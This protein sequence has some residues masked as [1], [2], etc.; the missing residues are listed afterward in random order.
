MEKSVNRIYFFDYLENITA[1][2][3]IGHLKRFCNRV[4]DVIL[5]SKSI[6]AL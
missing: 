3:G 6:K 5:N 4:S 2:M 1:T